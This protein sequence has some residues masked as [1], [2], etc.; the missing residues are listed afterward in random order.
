MI[1]CASCRFSGVRSHLVRPRWAPS[2]DWIV[3]VVGCRCHTGLASAEA[4]FEAVFDIEE[5]APTSTS[6]FTLLEKAARSPE[7]QKIGPGGAAYTGFV[8]GAQAP[9]VSEH[10]QVSIGLF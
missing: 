7:F 9:L 1:T 5:S 2:S 4:R 10:P 3:V 8:P 6:R